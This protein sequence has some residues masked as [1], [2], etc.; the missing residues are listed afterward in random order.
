[1]FFVGGSPTV[2]PGCATFVAQKGESRLI[3]L[4]VFKSKSLLRML[5]GWHYGSELILL[6]WD[7]TAN[8]AVLVLR[9][10]NHTSNET[11]KTNGELSSPPRGL[12]GWANEQIYLLS[13]IMYG[14]YSESEQVLFELD[15]G[16]DT[17]Y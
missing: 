8:V 6:L 16:Y 10:L 1:M 2:L 11:I 15:V 5:P 7:K 4:E 12:P 14:N 9:H 13:F 17:V 3:I